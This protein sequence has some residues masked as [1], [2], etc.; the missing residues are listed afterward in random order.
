MKAV[1]M[2]GGEGSRLRPMTCAHPKPMVPVADKPVMAYA[3]ELLARHGVTGAAVTVMYMPNSIIDY[4]GDGG[5]YGVKLTYFTETT[6]LGTAGSVKRA[7]SVLDETFVVLSGDGITDCDIT[8]ALEFHR[9]KGAIATMVLKKVSSPLEYGV[10]LTD[11]N[12]RVERFIEKPGWG[13]ACSD[14][15][16][17]G[18]YILEPRVLE[19]IP[20]NRPWDFGRD[21]FPALVREGSCVYGFLM[22][23]YWCDI[24]DNAAYLKA[25]FDLLDG[26]MEVSGLKPG[27]VARMPGSVIDKSAILEAPC[28]IAPG[29]RV[30]AGARIGAYSVIG[31]GSVIG[32]DSSVKRSVVWPG[33][34]VGE[35]NSLRGATLL[36]G[37]TTRD[38]VSAFEESVIGDGA[39]IG[40]GV[41]IMSSTRVWPHKFIED[42][43]RVDRNVVWGNGLSRSLV[44]G[45]FTLDSPARA[46]CDAQG[47]ASALKF[48]KIVVARDASITSNAFHRAVIAGLMAQGAQVV[49]AQAQPL[50]VA[51]YAQKLARAA[52]ALYVARDCLI[53]F[54]EMGA[55][56]SRGECRLVKAAL[57]REDYPTPFSAVTKPPITMSACDQG[58][59]SQVLDAVSGSDMSRVRVA[60]FCRNDMVLSLAERVLRQSGAS[61]RAEWEE[62]M[63]V[64]G[65]GEICVWLDERGQRADFAD[66]HGMLTQPERTL[67]LC[68][69]A[70]ESGEGELI[71]PRGTTRAVEELAERYGVTIR[72][73]S[74]DDGAFQRELAQEHGVQ[75]ALHFD[76]I[77]S[78]TVVLARL[79]YA[80][81]TMRDALKTFSPLYRRARSVQME[82]RDKGKLVNRLKEAIPDAD[83]EDGVLIER[84]G[85]WAFINPC[86]D[87]R[88]CLVTSEAATAEFARELCDFCVG[89]IERFRRGE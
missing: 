86:G 77:E 44:D 50:C 52:G 78:A 29:A 47:Y 10:V 26:K 53:P 64:P 73:T 70:V 7:A 57:A 31:R 15:V 4:F 9:E 42:G 35:R 72:H 13:E 59:M 34:K 23:G 20:E 38:D 8:A 3:L 43:E 11:Q 18:I 6:P 39:V 32:R 45:V 58:Y 88:E 68:W 80:N 51:L 71:L 56:L 36:S 89:H 75:L 61:V 17:T 66:E 85:G 63:M 49:D 41:T 55:R 1:I 22:D 74:C 54:G 30:E 16:N 48:E 24:G 28:Y 67:L 81:T 62:E 69:A 14:S 60:I 65:P 33:V 21:L 82:P 27:V 46:V 5:D 37:A 87:K 12:G 2:A 84:D 25:N 79:A 76:G 83:V 40:E 19:K